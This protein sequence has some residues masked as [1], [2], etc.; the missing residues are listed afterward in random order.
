MEKIDNHSKDFLKT[1][2]HLDY[3]S[4]KVEDLFKDISYN[5]FLI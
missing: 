5:L 3:E 4:L 1:K 2:H